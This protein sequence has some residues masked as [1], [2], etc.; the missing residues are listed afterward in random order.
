LDL[1][2]DGLAGGREVGDHSTGFLG[3]I[4]GNIGKPYLKDIHV[5]AI[6]NFHIVDA[7]LDIK[8]PP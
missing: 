8:L 4:K 7:F 6:P 1:Q 5:P 3:M 2:K